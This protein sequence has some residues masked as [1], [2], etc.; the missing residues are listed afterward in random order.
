MHFDLNFVEYLTKKM[1]ILNANHFNV[2]FSFIFIICILEQLESLCN[3]HHLHRH[4]ICWLLFRSFIASFLLYEYN[5]QQI[6]SIH[7]GLVFVSINL[8]QID[9]DQCS[10]SNSFF[11]D[12]HK[13]HTPSTQVCFFWIQFQTYEKKILK[14]FRLQV[15]FLLISFRFVFFLVL[16][17][18]FFPES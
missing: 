1:I 10:N 12:T 6:Q 15:T 5:H 2:C 11:S 7:S 17:F 16:T 13:C 4:S 3:H 9:M 8:K 18:N 14:H